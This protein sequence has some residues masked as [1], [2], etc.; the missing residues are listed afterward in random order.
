MKKKIYV[1]LTVIVIG[2]LGL[3]VFNG[4]FRIKKDKQVNEEV[5]RNTIIENDKLNQL[6]SEENINQD[7]ENIEKYVRYD[8][9]GN[10][11]VGVLFKNL[12]EKNEKSL[13]FEVML[14]TH[15]VELDGI[16]YASLVSLKT[17]KDVLI[18]EGFKWVKT[19]GGGHHIFGYLEIPRVYQGTDIVDGTTKYIELEIKGLD[20]IESRKFKWEKD[21]L[22]SFQ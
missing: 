19:E 10:V 2:A 16:D 3:G 15:S 5:Q 6:D 22:K 7:E 4:L 14:N 8:S 12:L 11:D 17:D 20:D 21:I 9:Q 1:V 18:S 13:Q